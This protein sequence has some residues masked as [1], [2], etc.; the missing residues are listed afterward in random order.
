MIFGWFAEHRRH[1]L[2]EQPFPEA[3]LAILNANLPVYALL[4]EEEQGR[5]RDILRILVAEKSWEGCGGLEMTDEIK[6]T[7]AAQA[8]LL[9][10]NR[11]HSYYANVESI[12]VYPNEYRSREQRR[13]AA[14]V[15][16]PMISGRLGESW[17]NGP[18]VLSWFDVLQGGSNSVDGNNVVFHEFAHKLDATDSDMN[19]VPLLE[20]DTQVEEWSEVMQAEYE[21][22]V[23]AV[24]RGHPTLLNGYGATNPAEFFAVA[25]ECFFEKPIQMQHHHARLY[26]VLQGYYHQ[27]PAARIEAA[28]PHT[29]A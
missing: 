12:L 19:G 10:L 29:E 26:K 6:V 21:E 7:I 28:A 14:G 27:D 8:S 2:L 16:N 11:E 24:E 18:I 22:L 3:W 25:T 5:L 23:S 17:S 4:S 15:V 13:D 20:N 1:K 9:I